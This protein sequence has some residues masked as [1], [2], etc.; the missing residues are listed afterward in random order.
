MPD[1]TATTA[2]IRCGKRTHSSRI[3]GQLPDDDEP[4]ADLTV[5]P[6][7]APSHLTKRADPDQKKRR[8]CGAPLTT[9]ATERSGNEG[10]QFGKIGP[11]ADRRHIVVI[12]PAHD[13]ELLRRFRGGKGP[14][15]QF[16]RDNVVT[17][18]VHE[19]LGQ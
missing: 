10:G 5:K 12:G 14:L 2:P 16:D 11:P 17:I 3:Y 4:H 8:R 7:I 1:S 13:V 15:A 18:S 19:Q 9:S 6:A